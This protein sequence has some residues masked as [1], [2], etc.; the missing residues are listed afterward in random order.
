MAASVAHPG[1]SAGAAVNCVADGG[2]GFSRKG[3]GAR[4]VVAVRGSVDGCHAWSS[5]GS[6]CGGQVVPLLKQGVESQSRARRVT[7]TQAVLRTSSK[8]E[9]LI[10]VEIQRGSESPFETKWVLDREPRS[11][12]FERLPSGDEPRIN[13]LVVD[14]VLEEMTAVTGSLIEGAVAEAAVMLR[15]GKS[16]LGTKG[17]DRDEFQLPSTEQDSGLSE[18]AILE[19]A[20]AEAARVLHAKG[21]TLGQKAVYNQDEIELQEA[22]LETVKVLRGGQSSFVG[23]APTNAQKR[24]QFWDKVQSSGF[25]KALKKDGMAIKSWIQDVMPQKT[26]R[27]TEVN[28]ILANDI[29]YVKRKS[30]RLGPSLSKKVG[31]IVALRVIE[32]ESAVPAAPAFWPKPYYPELRGKDLL[33]ADLRTLERYSSYIQGVFQSFQVPLQNDYDPDEVAAYFH[34]RPH[35]LVFR[36]LEVGIA[37]ASVALER[38]VRMATLKKN[39]LGE[40]LEEDELEVNLRTAASLKQA[41]LGLGTTFIKVAQSLSARPDLIGTETAKVLAE[42]QDRLPPF[43]KEEAIAIIEEELGC[44]VSEAFSFFSD[45]PVAA[46]SFGQVYRALTTS[47]EEVAVKVQ[48]PNMLFNVAR[49]VYILRIGLVILKQVA[50]LSNN[51]ALIA[52]EIGQG[53]YGELDY[54]HEAANAAEFALTHKHVPWLYV[55]KTLPHMTR[56][57]VLVMEWLNGDRPFDLQN[58]AKG[59]PY[60]N[61]T[62]PSLEVQ[63]EARRRLLNM[64]NKGTEAALI[65]LLETGVMHA[66]PHPGNILLGRNGQLQFI[67]FGL[68]CHVD[69]KHQGAMLAAIAHL[70]NGDWHS[71]T[72]DLADMDVLKPTTDRFAVRLALERAFGEGP[73]AIF[74]NG[75]PNPNFSFNK[76]VKKFFKI[77]YK[78]RFRLPPY[79][80]LVLR[81]L[82]SLEG[83]GL[84]VNPDFKTFGAAYPYAVR[85]VLYD[86]S[87]TTQRVL[88]SLLLTEKNAFKWDR[89]SS[90]LVISQKANADRAALET[91]TVPIED[92][93][94]DA[95]STNSSTDSSDSQPSAGNIA[96]LLFSRKGVGIRRVIYEADARDLACMLTSAR[97]AKYRRM[98]AGRLGEALFDILKKKFP[99]SSSETVTTS[100]PK[101]TADRIARDK[102]LQ[103]ILKSMVGRLQS[104]P[105]LL[106]KAGWAAASVALWAMALAFH[107]FAIHLSNQLLDTEPGQGAARIQSTRNN[108]TVP[109]AVGS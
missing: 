14:R 84:A 58:V 77:A 83:F 23:K 107:N 79:Y 27:K 33:A 78:F 105:I 74:K 43:P 34:R 50:K 8:E 99:T 11:S 24:R 90:L 75:V 106:A 21:S 82:A 100:Q 61:G 36:L 52:D 25:A 18:D 47:G 73:D 38:S 71:L 95:P 31:E 45:E 7:T 109:V 97:A 53:L 13:E 80:T 2:L 26:S 93:R 66:D 29:E 65:Q 91:V 59:L 40:I 81:S 54:R 96:E 37:F 62:R 32:D 108:K 85:R 15:D 88:R 48:R 3:A 57:K 92:S 103:L 56:R 64:V 67:D 16:S 22:M 17:G 46:A 69:K 5:K 60:E 68:I 12:D 98:V 101:S 42:L 72:E 6:F 76:I 19:E 94:V 10:N 87:P 20:A 86:Y 49:D 1:T 41:L 4:S 104:Q 35:V 89:I 102:R 55:P 30:T 39:K 51:Y 28:N 63:Q 9:T 70:V 44:R